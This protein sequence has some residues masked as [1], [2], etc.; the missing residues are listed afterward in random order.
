MQTCNQGL[1]VAVQ[2]H[3]TN[4]HTFA[5]PAFVTAPMCVHQ[6]HYAGFQAATMS[7]LENQCQPNNVGDMRR[8]AR[9]LHA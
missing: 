9:V 7:V 8:A 5:S 4:S 1:K 3:E 6:H 2:L